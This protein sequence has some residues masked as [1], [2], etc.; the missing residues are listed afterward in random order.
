MQF[1]AST[2]KLFSNIVYG[3][4]RE[5][6]PQRER[7]VATKIIEAWMAEG[8]SPYQISLM[9]NGGTPTVKRGINKHGVAYDTAAY[10]EKVLAFLN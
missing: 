6:T 9:W 8:Y 3:E 10:A 2:W 1:L 4:V 7:Y 5:M